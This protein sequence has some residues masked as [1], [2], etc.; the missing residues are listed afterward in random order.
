MIHPLRIHYDKL[1][2]AVVITALGCTIGWVHRQQF[3]LR[4][5]HAEPASPNHPM[6]A[7]VPALRKASVASASVWPKPGS[8]SRGEGWLYEVFTPPVIHYAAATRAFA[9]APTEPEQGIADKGSI[10][11]ELLAVKPE[12][13]R[14]QLAGYFGAAD[15]YLVAFTSPRSAETILARPGHRFSDLKLTFKSFEVS[16]VLVA[17]AEFGPVHEVAALAVLLDEQSGREVVL[18]S[19]KQRLADGAVAVFHRL[20]DRDGRREL[21]TGRWRC[22]TDRMKGRGDVSCAKG[23]PLPRPIR[24]VASNGSGLSRPRWS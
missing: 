10:P 1:L 24:S 9:L 16:K 5:L 22:F 4:S 17:E 6:V 7:Y 11:W 23:I 8:Q 20:D 21:P 18:D 14:L 13:Y 19:R 3:R 15:E 2:L 12:A